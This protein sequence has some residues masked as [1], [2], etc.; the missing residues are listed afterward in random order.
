GVVEQA[1]DGL[2]VLVRVDDVLLDPV[3]LP[4]L[5]RQGRGGLLDPPRVLLVDEMRP[6]TAATLDQLG[7]GTRQDAL[8]TIP[9]DAGPVARQERGVEDPRPLLVLIF[10]AEPLVCVGRG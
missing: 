1:G 2:T 7:S 9:E 3:V 5:R 4:F 6:V 10:E 8:A